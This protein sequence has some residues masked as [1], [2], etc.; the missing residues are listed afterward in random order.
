MWVSV[1]VLSMHQRSSIRRIGLVP[2]RS[3][4]FNNIPNEWMNGA[5]LALSFFAPGLLSRIAF[6]MWFP[7]GS[8]VWV[9]CLAGCGDE[10]KHWLLFRTLGVPFS[11]FILAEYVASTCQ[12]VQC[13][14]CN[15]K[16]IEDDSFSEE[17]AQVILHILH[18]MVRKHASEHYA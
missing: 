14:P 17:H 8:Y 2:D 10:L 3:I 15:A 11:Y 1:C 7:R 5:G 18:M 4:N 13:F 16:S 12:G 9:L 6:A